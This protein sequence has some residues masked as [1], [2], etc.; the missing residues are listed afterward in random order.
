M[1]EEKGEQPILQCLYCN[2]YILIEKI[3][4]GIFRHGVFK[5]TMKQVDPHE[6]KENCDNYAKQNLIYGC[7]KPFKITH[8]N[9]VFKIE[10]C[11]YM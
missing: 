4:C 1:S 3:N 10:I 2:E 7:G 9:Q 6:T 11:D 5:D 8:I